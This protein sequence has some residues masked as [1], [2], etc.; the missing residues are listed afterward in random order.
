MNGAFIVM[1][2]SILYKILTGIP[3]RFALSVLPM[4]FCDICSFV[5]GVADAATAGDALIA[6][7]NTTSRLPKN[8]MGVFKFL[9]H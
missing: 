2:P 7:A 8:D 6:T 1:V 5:N 4:I 3:I 9:T